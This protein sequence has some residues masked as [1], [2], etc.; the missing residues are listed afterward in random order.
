MTPDLAPAKALMRRGT[1]LLA[2]GLL[3]VAGVMV[4]ALQFTPT[5][6]RQGLAQKIF[7]MHVPS[8]TVLLWIAMP[9]AGLMSVLYL[10]L[11]EPR[12]DRLAAVTAEVGTQAVYSLLD[13]LR[14]AQEVAELLPR[15]PKA[16]R[17]KVLEALTITEIAV[18][19]FKMDLALSGDVEE[20]H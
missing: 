13:L 16:I 1:I 17:L 2:L 12:F 15:E 4:M 11:R 14:S 6:A 8:A 9:F 20:V 3:G 5:E 18:L 19:R 7:Y 10:W